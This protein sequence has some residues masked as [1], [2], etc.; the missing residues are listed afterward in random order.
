MLALSPA[1]NKLLEEAIKL[2]DDARADLAAALIESLDDAR[3]PDVESTWS[4]EIAGR[5]RDYEAGAVKP[6]PWY[7]ARKMIF[8]PRGAAP[9]R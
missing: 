8:G 4:D 9:G 3:D 6:M 7:E 5:L 1:A 2:P